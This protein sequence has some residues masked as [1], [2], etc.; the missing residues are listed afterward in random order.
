MKSHELKQWR[1]RTGYSQGTLARLLAVD[2]MTISRWERNIMRIPPFLKLAL[3]YI[4][5]K[6]DELKPIPKRTRTERK[7]GKNP[8]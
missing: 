3:A 5:L 7:G 1:E 4:E 6:G 2:V 8:R